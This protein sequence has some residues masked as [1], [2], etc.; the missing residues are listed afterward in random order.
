[1]RARGRAKAALSPGPAIASAERQTRS[2]LKR[3]YRS[4]GAL[5]PT[6]PLPFTALHLVLGVHIARV[7]ASAAV[8]QVPEAT[9]TIDNVVA[10]TTVLL[11]VVVT[12]A[13]LVGAPIA[14]NHVVAPQRADVV[15]VLGAYNLLACIGADDGFRQGH[16]AGCDQR[17]SH[18]RKH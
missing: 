18:H 9:F 8:D 2:L 13:Y 11:I 6:S 3:S 7:D 4:F 5:L 16:P 17:R 15:S 1:M 10:P 12:T 14:Q